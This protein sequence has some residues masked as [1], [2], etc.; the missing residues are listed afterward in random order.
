MSYTYEFAPGFKLDLADTTPEWAVTL[1]S[2]VMT[3][4]D[5]KLQKITDKLDNSVYGSDNKIEELTSKINSLEYENTLLKQEVSTITDR[6][7]RSSLILIGMDEEVEGGP[8]LWDRV[9]HIFSRLQLRTNISMFDVIRIGR[10]VP[11]KTRSVRIDFLR[12]DQRNAVWGNK[13]KLPRGLK[14]QECFSEDTL[15]NRKALQPFYQEALKDKNSN[16]KL[17]GDNLFISGARY[18]AKNI[19]EI[20]V[21]PTDTTITKNGTTLFFGMKSPLSNFYPASFEIDDVKYSSSEQYYQANCA[22]SSGN[23]NLYNKIMK[24]T[25]PYKIKSLGRGIKD[26]AVTRW[27]RKDV[28]FKGINAKFSQNPQLAEALLRTGESTIGEANRNDSFWGI[29]KSIN[30]PTAFTAKW[31]GQNRCGV[32]LMGIREALRAEANLSQS[33]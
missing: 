27:D 1:C 6:L 7:N 32:I 22:K 2:S 9:S 19:E 11:G 28:M 21:K 3:L 5:T 16:A 26:S 12:I 25:N 18:T 14:L 10:K 29:G 4:L 31:N 24:T 17:V 23:F 30:D 15:L 8:E 13:S 33:F 20:P